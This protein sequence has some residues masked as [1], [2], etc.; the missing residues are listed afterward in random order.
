LPAMASCP[1]QLHAMTQRIRGQARSYRWWRRRRC[2][3][4]LPLLPSLPSLPS[5]AGYGC[6]SQRHPLIGL[7]RRPIVGARLPAK[8]SCPTQLHAMTQRIRGQAHSYRSWRRPA[9]LR[10]FRI[11]SPTSIRIRIEIPH[12]LLNDHRLPL[13]LYSQP[14]ANAA[15]A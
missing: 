1:T 14:R 4:Q 10:A 2:L 6:L 11:S 8:A 7:K 13:R 3:A 15:A 9:L 5:L 12:H